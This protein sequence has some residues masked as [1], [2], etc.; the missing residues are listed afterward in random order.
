MYAQALSLMSR[1]YVGSLSFDLKEQNVRTIFGPFGPIK[2]I[3]MSYD[4][5][6]GVSW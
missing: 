3:N 6:T 4:P 5:V 1:V 2:S